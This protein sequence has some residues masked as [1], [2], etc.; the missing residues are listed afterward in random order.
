MFRSEYG[1]YLYPADIYTRRITT[2]YGDHLPFGDHLPLDAPLWSELVRLIYNISLIYNVRRTLV[3]IISIP[4]FV[5]WEVKTPPALEWNSFLKTEPFL[6]E[7]LEYCTR[8][9]HGYICFTSGFTIISSFGI[10]SLSPSFIWVLGIEYTKL[11][12]V[13]HCLLNVFRISNEAG[14]NQKWMR[15]SKFILF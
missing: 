2:P 9:S 8:D 3:L 4:M 11:S 7:T 13:L 14:S 5:K 1:G 15:R 10:L 6:G 12:I